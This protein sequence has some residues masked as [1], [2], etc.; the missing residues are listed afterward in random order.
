MNS[1]MSETYLVSI[2]FCPSIFDNVSAF[3][4][5]TESSWA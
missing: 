3:D 4:A 2:N 5:T 1:A